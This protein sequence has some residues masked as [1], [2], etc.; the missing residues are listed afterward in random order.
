MFYYYVMSYKTHV[1]FTFAIS[2]RSFSNSASTKFL[3]L[4]ETGYQHFHKF[5]AHTKWLE[6][7]NTK[8]KKCMNLILLMKPRTLKVWCRLYAIF[9]N[10]YFFI[11]CK[12][13]RKKSKNYDAFLFFASLS[14]CTISIRI[15][16]L[17]W[18]PFPKT[19]L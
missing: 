15:F 7:K 14:T 16:N 5:V 6:Y 13:I 19:K 10:I 18:S 8:Q 9:V 1:L 11:W 2:I 4:S 3:M 12:D 17:E